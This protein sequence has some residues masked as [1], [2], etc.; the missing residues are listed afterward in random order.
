MMWGGFP[1]LFRKYEDKLYYYNKNIEVDFYIAEEAYAIQASYSIGNEETL[2]REIDGLK[3][4]HSF[5]PLKRM[6][7][8]TFD[9]EDTIMLDDG[10]VIEVIPAWKWLME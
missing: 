5:Q 1:E 8:V 10:R 9:E 4:L 6:V 2:K 3:K 7:I